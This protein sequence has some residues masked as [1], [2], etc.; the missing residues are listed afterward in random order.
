MV[1]VVVVGVVVVVVG[2]VVVVVG[3]VVV[4]VVVGAVVVVVGAVVVVVVVGVVVVVVVVGVVVVVIGVVVVVV[5]GLGVVEGAEVALVVV[6]V[7]MDTGTV[8]VE[9]MLGS[10]SIQTVVGAVGTMVTEMDSGQG[11][12]EKIVAKGVIVVLVRL[13]VREVSKN[14]VLGV[15]ED[16]LST[17]LLELTV[18]M[19]VGEETEPGEDTVAVTR[20]EEA[21]EEMMVLKG[22]VMALEL[23]VKGRK[24]GVAEVALV[25][26]EGILGV[27]VRDSGLVLNTVVWA[28]EVAGGWVV[29]IVGVEPE[30]VLVVVL[31]LILG[32]VVARV[33]LVDTTVRVGVFVV[34]LLVGDLG[35]LVLVGVRLVGVSVVL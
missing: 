15:T 1:V 30:G 32:V 24:A 8:G 35:S 4:V 10:T 6:E 20:V 29:A 9:V 2:V 3:V 21:E 25:A 34:R 31:V 11:V 5:G 7:R 33:I 18:V 17:L 28:V 23:V 22:V 13:E 12:V 19:E 14:V 27:V 26:E 16:L